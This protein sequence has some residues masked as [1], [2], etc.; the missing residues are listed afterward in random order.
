MA[1]AHPPSSSSSSS[2]SSTPAAPAA[3]PPP[4][5]M[6]TGS[7]H[8]AL[9]MSAL[10]LVGGG[11]AYATARSTQSLLAGALFGSGFGAAAYWIKGDEQARGFRFAALN[12]A[13]LSGVMAVRYARSRKAMPAVPLALLGAASGAYHFAKWREW[14]E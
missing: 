8:A 3:P 13:L 4:L 2:S 12:S 6:P 10:C 1:G 9:T 7:A 11:A 14:A 5:S